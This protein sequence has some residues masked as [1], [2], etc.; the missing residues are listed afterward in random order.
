MDPTK[1]HHINV[2]AALIHVFG[3]FVQSVGVLISSIVIKVNPD[4]KIA[5]PI[6][7]IIFAL[8]VFMTT[9]TILRDTANILME[10]TPSS[11]SY[12]LIKKDLLKIHGVTSLH[13]LQIW[14]ITV[15]KVALTVHLET[16][17]G[18]T[19]CHHDQVLKEAIKVLRDKHEINI[20]TI[21]IDTFYNKQ[22]QKCIL[23][24]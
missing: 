20:S 10:G 9:I 2:R 6:C 1:K 13:D 7:T 24:L 17:A 18:T 23:L 21:Q 5:D 16:S 19:V 4:Y 14:S 8:I 15:N 11:T 3:D 22:C 12:G